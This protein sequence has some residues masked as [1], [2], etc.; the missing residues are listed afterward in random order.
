MLD[1]IIAFSDN[2]ITVKNIRSA[3]G[4]IDQ[5]DI[6][7]LFEYVINQDADSAIKKYNL[8][9]ETGVSSKVFIDDLCSFL[10]EI[11]LIKINPNNDKIFL[12]EELKNN[13]YSKTPFQMNDILRMLNISLRLSSAF[14]RIDNVKISIEVLIMKFIS[15]IAQNSKYNQFSKSNLNIPKSDLK[16]NDNNEL[17]KD[18]QNDREEDQVVQKEAVEPEILSHNSDEI[19]SK[20]TVN[21]TNLDNNQKLDLS[22]IEKF[23]LLQQNWEDILCKIDETNSKLSSFLE[24]TQIIS[25]SDNVLHLE[26]NNGNSFIKK[27]IDTDQSI[28]KDIIK[29]ICKLEVTISVKVNKTL[30]EKEEVSIENTKEENHP[31]LDDAINIFKGKIIS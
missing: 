16:S 23:D 24:E 3:I 22:D 19:P 2:K 28:I 12:S 4:L 1:Q 11:M 20:D 17:I 10:N 5:E 8:I 7:E 18:N 29:N 6:F 30:D 9:L 26:V 14:K 31:L 13:I 21:I 15:I 27:V 25:L